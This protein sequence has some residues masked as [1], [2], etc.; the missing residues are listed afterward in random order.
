MSRQRLRP[1]H[2][3]QSNCLTLICKVKRSLTDTLSDW[4]W[5]MQLK[6]GEENAKTPSMWETL[7]TANARRQIG[8]ILWGIFRERGDRWVG[9]SCIWRLMRVCISILVANVSALWKAS[10]SHL[11]N[12]LLG[13]DFFFIVEILM[14]KRVA[15]SSSASANITP[16]FAQTEWHRN[17]KLKLVHPPKCHPTDKSLELTAEE[18]RRGIFFCEMLLDFITKFN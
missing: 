15:T 10:F 1:H 2:N 3:S 8:K 16:S 5:I 12:L 17:D 18:F 7:L 9:G 14:Q 4:I 11:A 6:T 13:T